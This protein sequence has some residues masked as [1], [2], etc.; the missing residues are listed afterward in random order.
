MS[1]HRQSS[2]G[3]SN[4]KWVLPEEPQGGGGMGLVPR[5]VYGA[6]DIRLHGGWNLSTA[7]IGIAPTLALGSTRWAAEVE[8][9][10]YEEITDANHMS[11]S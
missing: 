8:H 1:K 9:H 4:G 3:R 2:P 7:G 6:P 5:G 10:I 11:P